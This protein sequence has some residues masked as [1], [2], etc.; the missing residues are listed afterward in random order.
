MQERRGSTGIQLKDTLEFFWGL[1]FAYVKLLVLDFNEKQLPVFYANAQILK[2]HNSL[3]LRRISSMMSDPS[4]WMIL[5]GFG[6]RRCI[7]LHSFSIFIRNLSYHKNAGRPME[8]CTIH[9]ILVRIPGHLVFIYGE[10]LDNW[11]LKVFEAIN[12][13]E[14]N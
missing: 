1:L 2:A 7:Y 13:P 8:E 12:S 9:I 10:Q 4:S 6:K 14:T 3:Y 5:T 11:V